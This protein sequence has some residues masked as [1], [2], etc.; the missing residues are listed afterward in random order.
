MQKKEREIVNLFI[1][2]DFE[3]D[4]Q[5]TWKLSEVL[6]DFYVESLILPI[7]N[8]QRSGVSSKIYYVHRTT[9]A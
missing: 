7:L 6:A 1:F 5:I 3:E 8:S 2:G 9:Q 4:Y